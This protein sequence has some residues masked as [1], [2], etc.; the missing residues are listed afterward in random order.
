[1]VVRFKKSD[2]SSFV[3]ATCVL[4]EAD[5]V[6]I[7]EAGK[8]ALNL[9]KGDPVVEE[10]DIV[11]EREIEADDQEVETEAVLGGATLDSSQLQQVITDTETGV[12]G[13]SLTKFW[14]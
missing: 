13:H 4:N 14:K 1:M 11:E 10:E 12:S 7:V 2:P 5:L 3:T 6:L 8:L 9:V